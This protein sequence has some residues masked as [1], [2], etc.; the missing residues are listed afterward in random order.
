MK[1][2]MLSWLKRKKLFAVLFFGVVGSLLAQSSFLTDYA[3]AA[4]V[5]PEQCYALNGTSYNRNVKWMHTEE[6]DACVSEKYCEGG[7]FTPLTCSEDVYKRLTG[8]ITV[9]ASQC[10]GYNGSTYAAD[11]AGGS[12]PEQLACITQGY[13]KEDKSASYR[14][15]LL[16]SEEIYKASDQYKVVQTAAVIKAKEDAMVAPVTKL[17]CGD[18]PAGEA[19]QSAYLDCAGKVRSYYKQC[20]VNDSG[21]IGSENT[22]ATSA[23][24]AKCIREKMGIS[25]PSAAAIEAAIDEGKKTAEQIVIDEGGEEDTVC[26]NNEVLKDGECVAAVQCTGGQLGWILCPIMYTFSDFISVAADFLESMLFIN[27]IGG[28]TALQD[29]WSSFVGIA[30]LLLVVAF[31]VVIFSQA[32]SLGLNAYGIKKML[33]RI[34]AA[35][36]L[37]N[38]SY[39]IC[40]LALDIVNIIG[41][42]VGGMIQSL[43]P[44]TSTFGGQSIPKSAT[45]IAWV[46]VGITALI[47]A[48]IAAAVGA[49]A[50]LVPVLLSM[51]FGVLSIFLA[52]AMRHAIVILLVIISPLA[53]AAMILPNTEP[54]FAKW[55]KMFTN[56]L[57]MYPVAM[58]LLYGAQLVGALVLLSKNIT[59]DSGT[60]QNPVSDW[61]IDVVVALII[62]LVPTYGL[63][64]YVSNADKILAMATGA[65][66][67]IGASAR[68][69]SQGWAKEKY[70]NSTFARTRAWGKAAK[71][72]ARIERQGKMEGNSPRAAYNRAMSYA[73]A[74]SA[75]DLR[76]LKSNA[77]KY[78][79]SASNRAA[80]EADKIFDEDEA[81]AAA[82]YA[83]NGI[84]G[85]LMVAHARSGRVV[86]EYKKEDGT[87]GYKYGRKLTEAE[88]AAAVKWTMAN[89]KLAERQEVYGSDW[90]SKGRTPE[91]SRALDA[92]ND[93]Y[94]HVNKD[95]ARFGN[96]FGGTMTSG[97]VGGDI[98]VDNAALVNMASGKTAAEAIIDNDMAQTLADLNALS[99]DELT[100]RITKFHLLPPEFKEDGVP[101]AESAKKYAAR[102]RDN[103]AKLAQTIEDNRE[104][105]S[106][107]KPEFAPALA[108]LRTRTADPQRRARGTSKD[109]EDKNTRLNRQRAQLD[110]RSIGA[111]IP[112]NPDENLRNIQPAL[113][114]LEERDAAKAP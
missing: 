3:S 74:A 83:K 90:A 64:K 24:Q 61:I 66:G 33:P 104:L 88:H 45:P 98:G 108:E 36:I 17:I 50:F 84:A 13:C 12:T 85:P 25:S 102:F 29:A 28:Q 16:C 8:K 4:T 91:Y 92:M 27:P 78:Q 95:V 53:F 23:D 93:G 82:N 18:A 9:S 51:A 6:Q 62:V 67:K 42:S 111:Q 65:V 96:R 73:A 103:A 68:K 40:T 37:I 7:V 97:T 2:A 112:L 22:A 58:F 70:N 54:L 110:D 20:S 10:Y 30:N 43:M 57:F 77:G 100:E 101:E 21:P 72:Q 26:S 44:D 113:E 89:G 55:R 47:A 32:T 76:N 38:L 107:V 106:R 35:A 59:A 81:N 49:I 105:K 56:M 52:V 41:G 87:I 63:W 114:K 80:K 79:V 5:T 94:F 60:G 14:Q 19:A 75:G 31:L 69:A 34:I 11:I 1:K 71:E 109:G 48:G 39:F 99:D 15:P 46:Q 86:Q